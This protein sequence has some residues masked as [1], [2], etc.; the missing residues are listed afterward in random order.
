MFRKKVF[1]G[2]LRVMKKG[3]LTQGRG[4]PE[5][6]SR[7]GAI[8]RGRNSHDLRNERGKIVRSAAGVVGLP[9]DVMY[10]EEANA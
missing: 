2:V 6:P 8:R 3:T 9:E 10:A 4:G 5:G 7:S 1:R